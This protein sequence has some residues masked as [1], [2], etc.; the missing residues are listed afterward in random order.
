MRAGFIASTLRMDE[1]AFMGG[2]NVFSG[3]G[4]SVVN[5]GQILTG[6]GGTVG[7]LGSTVANE[8]LISAPLGKVAL[9][10]GEAATLD[11][12][13]DGFLQV[14]LPTSALAADGQAL[15]SNSGVIQADGGMVVLKA[16][17]V[18]QALR[19]AVN[20]PGEISARSVSGK[21]GAIVLEAGLGG[22]VRV[23]GALIADGDSVGGRIDV[24]GANG[25]LK[26]HHSAPPAP[27]AV[28]WYA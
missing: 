28:A 12:S 8:G 16:A 5:R 7:L 2:K 3:K 19:D 20:M 26:A 14:M 22:T 17:T 4:G 1:A 24:T 9:G 13:G 6:P 15:V 11:L 27:S 21:N 25:F 10:A 18:R 23:A